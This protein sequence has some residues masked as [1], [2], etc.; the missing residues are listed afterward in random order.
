MLDLL[1]GELMLAN[2]S[3]DQ[4]YEYWILIK[5]RD[6]LVDLLDAKKDK[7]NIFKIKKNKNDLVFEL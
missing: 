2:K 7:E 6:I 4:I 5:T 1:N 3:I